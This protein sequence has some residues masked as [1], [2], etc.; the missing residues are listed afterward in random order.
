M[1]TS[2]FEPLYRWLVSYMGACG[3]ILY[4]SKG[5]GGAP[6]P[7]PALI[8]AQIKS[9]G[10]QDSAIQEIL[11]LNKEMAPLQKAQMQFGLDANKTSFDQ[12]QADRG[13]MLDR[14]A[15][16]TG[17]QDTMLKDAKSFSEGDRANQL[18]GQ[19]QADVTSAFDNASTMQARDLARRG[20]NPSSGK[21]LAMGNESSIARAVASAGA[22]N[23]AR[24]SARLEGYSLTDR[25]ANTLAGYPAMGMSAT[26]Q[27]AS[28]AANGI[29]IANAGVGGLSAGLGS[30]SQMAASMGS[31]ASNMWGQQAN[32]HAN[33]QEQDQTGA[34]LGG[35]GGIAMGGASLWKSDRR[36]KQDI[37]LVG[38]DKATGLNLYEFSYIEDPERARYVGVM[39]DEVKKVRPDAVHTGDGGFD[40]V[41][42]AALGIEFKEVA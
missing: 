18:A 31:N 35:L 36:L 24:D 4:G 38:K 26:G 9:L 10:I 30:A 25:A 29:N 21:A 13:W 15:N 7:D 19:A 22:S 42:Y 8:A 12:S 41:N 3:F 1:L 6:P 20:V 37:E 17:L 27:G 16:L 39:A 5:G 33:M 14:R 23:K 11:A 40:M 34:I 2:L 28:L 32:Y